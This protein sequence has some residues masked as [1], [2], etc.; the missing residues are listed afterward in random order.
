MPTRQCACSPSLASTTRLPPP[1]TVRTKPGCRNCRHLSTCRSQLPQRPR[2]PSA[3][4]VLFCSRSFLFIHSSIHSFRCSRCR[5]IHHGR[6]VIHALAASRP[7]LALPSRS[8]TVRP[9]AHRLPLVGPHLPLC[10]PSRRHCRGPPPPPPPAPC[11]TLHQPRPCSRVEARR[12]DL[13]VQRPAAIPIG[14]V[15]PQALPRAPARMPDAQVPW[16]HGHC[17]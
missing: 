6:C 8:H 16:A 2:R 9:P 12:V 1:P 13:L 4:S 10:A 14:D 15:P 7:C 11:R 5:L 17:A 3:L